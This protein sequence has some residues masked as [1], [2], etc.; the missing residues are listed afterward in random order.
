MTICVGFPKESIPPASICNFR[1]DNMF[2]AAHE[3]VRKKWVLDCVFGLPPP[4][5]LTRFRVFRVC[6][7][8]EPPR[9]VWHHRTESHV[10]CLPC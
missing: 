7:R 2:R 6:R 1:C 3:E 10:R 4:R 9:P 5:L 8:A